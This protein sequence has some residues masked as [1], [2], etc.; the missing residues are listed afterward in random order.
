MED[1]LVALPSYLP[2]ALTELDCSDNLLTTIGEYL[3]N[4]IVFVD[5]RNN[6]ITRLPDL[7]PWLEELAACGNEFGCIEGL[8]AGCKSDLPGC[9][10]PG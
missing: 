9:G 3:S 4:R 8:P 1:Q 2:E 10:A 7:H 5:C 6:R